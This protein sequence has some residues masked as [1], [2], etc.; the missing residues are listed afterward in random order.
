M[1]P[2]GVGGVVLPVT[3]PGRSLLKTREDGLKQDPKAGRTS[4]RTSNYCTITRLDE[5]PTKD[6]TERDII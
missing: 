5:R 3:L 4:S 6:Y 2:G 1:R